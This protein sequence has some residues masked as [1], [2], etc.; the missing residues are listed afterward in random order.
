M[1][2][3]MSIERNFSVFDSRSYLT[4][5]YKMVDFEN[6]SLLKFYISC[7]DELPEGGTL[8]EFSG[9]PT[10]YSLI[11]AA[12]KVSQIHFSDRLASNLEEVKRWQQGTNDSFDWDPFIKR[13]VELEGG[14]A[15]NVYDIEERKKLIR[16][17]ITA[18]FYCN[19]FH[20]IPLL[21][22]PRVYYDIINVNFVPESITS[23]RDKWL[24]ALKNIT[25]LVKPGGLFIITAL[26]HAAYYELGD[27]VFPAVD[28]SEI[29]L[30]DVLEVNGFAKKSIRYKTI[31]AMPYRGYK[32]M[33]FMKAV[34]NR[35]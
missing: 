32:G 10:I 29:D 23:R 22:T 4:H 18:Y 7:Y 27:K 8:L 17:K 34:K 20:K 6:D 13:A 30:M 11:S 21:K 15:D 12:K 28:I 26:K 9:G 19:A 2:K 25:S 33:I 14:R 1:K 31:K 16:S 35:D 24:L 3:H 5:Y